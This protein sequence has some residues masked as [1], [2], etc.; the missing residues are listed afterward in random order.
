MKKIILASSSLY[1]RNLLSKL[2]L[3]FS[4]E[5]P[6]IDED[7]FK[8]K[9]KDSP[10]VLAETLSYEKAK[11]IFNS[12]QD[13][14]VIGSDQLGHF[15]RK[16]L[17]KG[18]THEGSF[19]T[20]KMIQGK[21]HELITSVTLLS[22]FDKITFTNIT[23]LTMRPLTDD[24]IH[25]YLELDKPYDCAGSFKLEEHGISLFSKIE[26]TDHTAII[27]LPLIELSNTL[28]KMGFSIPPQKKD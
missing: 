26:T 10:L 1:R 23:K 21:T 14:I 3:P 27:G 8:M 22:S 9:L 24:Q 20:L 18:K 25:H 11:K 7:S 12:H 2:G 6:E 19:E 13:A 28:I 5:A 4:Y 16:I 15:E 17:G